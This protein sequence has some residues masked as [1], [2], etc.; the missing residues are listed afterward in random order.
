MKLTNEQKEK[1][2]ELYNNFR[3]AL[4][5]IGF[6]NKYSNNNNKNKIQELYKYYN[7]KF[8][9]SKKERSCSNNTGVEE[10][11][12]QE[13]TS[14]K[15]PNYSNNE[16]L[17]KFIN[18]NNLERVL[19]NNNKNNNPFYNNEEVTDELKELIETLKYDI[20]INKEK[21]E[22]NKSNNI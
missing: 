12:G 7:N 14:H 9:H 21:N 17:T 6:K 15:V 4:R 20:K 8:I 3:Q 2:T 18:I 10:T 11:K 16:I 19:N 1:L 5:G 13:E 22:N